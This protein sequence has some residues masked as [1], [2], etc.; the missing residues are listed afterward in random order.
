M[1][2]I[3]VLASGRGTNLQAIIDACREGRIPDAGV[4]LVVSDKTDAYALERAKEAG[5]AT[6]VIL[7]EDFEKIKAFNLA[8][9]DA[10]DEAAVDLVC[11]AGFMRILSKS[12]VR[13]FYGRCLNI[14]PA[15]LPSF[16]GLEGQKQGWDYGVK[17]AGCTVH[18]VD[19]G[20]DT[21]PVILQRAV[22][23]DEGCSVD[24]LSAKILK[25]EHI[26]YPE[27]IKLHLGGRLTIDG[28]RVN[29]NPD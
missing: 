20:C 14:H 6:R 23:V 13:R 7:R 3:G 21:G 8:L 1:K 25:E 11:L 2:K 10:M 5:I 19:E 12:F 16:P 26:A 4:A 18:Y 29:I 22:T 28:R 15:L 9:A 24:E 27:A 17:V